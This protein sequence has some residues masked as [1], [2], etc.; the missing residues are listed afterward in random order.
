VGNHPQRADLG[1]F[2]DQL[3]R[4]A[5]AKVFL[6]RIIGQ[7]VERQHSQGLN[8]GDTGRAPRELA[9]KAALERKE[10]HHRHGRGSQEGE[11]ISQ[12]DSRGKPRVQ[13][14]SRR[15]FDS[16]GRFG[17]GSLMGSAIGNCSLGPYH[18]TYEAIAT[19]RDG[20][21]PACRSRG[22]VTL[23]GSSSAAF[24]G[25]ATIT[26]NGGD[27]VYLEDGTFAGF[28][29]ASITGNLSG[30]DINC[31]PQFPITRFVDRTGGITNCVETGARSKPKAME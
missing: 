4:H 13:G 15:R 3:V 9:E 22:V 31:A 17:L 26:G 20:L 27:G 7:I 12:G 18:L 11:S 23:L 2:G 29:S 1:K 25:G 5:I 19:T 14:F 16:D 30:L 28:L 10:E 21:D 6:L 8:P 24:S